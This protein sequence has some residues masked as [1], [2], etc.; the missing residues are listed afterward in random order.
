MSAPS[1]GIVEVSSTLILVLT[2]HLLQL[3][4]DLNLPDSLKKRRKFKVIE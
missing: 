4:A 1:H 3:G 2:A